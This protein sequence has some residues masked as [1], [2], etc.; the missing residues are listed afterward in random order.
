MAIAIAA[1]RESAP[2]DG[3][4]AVTPAVASALV[5]TGA[6]VL[7]EAGAGAGA[8]YTDEDYIAAGAEVVAAGA[9]LKNADI[10]LAV[11]TP[12]AATLK[13]MRK[14]QVLIG[15]FEA[16]G[17]PKTWDAVT[18]KGVTV[19]DLAKL[20][21]Q[22]SRAQTMDV[23]SSQ[24]SI[25][26]YRAAIVAAEAYGRYFPMM[27]TAAGTAKPASVLVLGAGVA[28]LQAIATARR[29]GSRVTGYDVRPAARE[30]V[31]SLG[32]Q[33]LTTKVASAD[34]AGGY[35][36][37]LTKEEAA[38]QQRELGE[39]IAKFDV[40]ITT[41]RVPGRK[42][43]LLVTKETVAAMRRGSV[44]VDLAAGPLG[45]NVAG[46]V[47]DQRTVTK[48]GVTLIGAESLAAHM[49]PAA[50]DAFS[51]NL[52]AVVTSLIKDGQ[53]VVNPEDEVIGAMLVQPAR[54]TEGANA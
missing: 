12:A 44:V 3:R 10:L 1:A 47:Q 38:E 54:K 35:A 19:I 29:L 50:S 26:G 4:V 39:A 21:R 37:E 20:P 18:A 51:K 11:G 43:P 8:A 15:L 27:V 17:D 5:K 30:E 48:G 40:V 32:A 31:T 9:L 49:A 25:A 14:D 28:G 23:L 53:I 34:G 52:A 36:R 24:A 6:R 16:W 42:P 2:S 22:I 45:G 41:A 13:A 46:V 33:F 7:I